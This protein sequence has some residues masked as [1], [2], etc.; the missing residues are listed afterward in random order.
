MIFR[1]FKRIL[2]FPLSRDFKWLPIEMVCL[3]GIIIAAGV[4]AFTDLRLY[5]PHSE[6]GRI[7]K[8]HFGAIAGYGKVLMISFLIYSA[9]YIHRRRN[10]PQGLNFISSG[11]E[12]IRSFFAYCLCLF[13]MMNFKLWSLFS[14][15]LWDAEYMAIDHMASPLIARLQTAM[16]TTGIVQDHY[17]SVY[18][19][20]FIAGYTV[21]AAV[22]REAF[23][24]ALTVS[25]AIFIL[26][27]IAYAIMPAYGPFL[28]FAQP[29]VDGFYYET[30]LYMLNFTERFRAS[31]GTLFNPQDFEAPLGAMPSL[32]TAHAIAM[33][34]VMWRI[35]PVLGMLMIPVAAYIVIF[36]MLTGFHYVVDIVAG[37]LLAL[38]AY[39]LTN[40]L[41]RRWKAA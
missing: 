26:G 37:I 36:A 11:I 20:I 5:T 10:N 15:R 31:G 22:G 8:G 27:G 17:F 18:L 21:A 39:W 28:Y 34:L 38:L 25:A 3:F 23:Q 7:V 24:R 41:T 29:G 4:T 6:G 32:H 2:P 19:Y 16:Q 13:L 35:H 12:F 33:L 9:G 30:Q 1:T 14:A 40:C